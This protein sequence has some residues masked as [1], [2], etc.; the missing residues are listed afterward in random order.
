MDWRKSL[1]GGA[2]DGTR[3]GGSRDPWRRCS[4]P[5]ETAPKVQQCER[6][7]AEENPEEKE[8]SLVGRDQLSGC[9]GRPLRRTWLA[10]ARAKA[11][12]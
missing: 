11:E 6:S 2:W 5:A 12:K 9:N 10:T 7:L 1:G 3:F 8:K 4:C